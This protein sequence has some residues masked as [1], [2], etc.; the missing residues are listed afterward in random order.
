MKIGI[1]YDVHRLKEGRDLILGGVKIPYPLGLDG[2]SDAD[3]LV[4]AIMDAILGALAMGDIG[5][6]FPD[7]DP[8]Y[9]GASSMGLLKEVAG[10]MDQKGYRIGNVD[11]LLIAQKPKISPYTEEMRKNIAEALGTDTACINVKATTE[12]KLGFTGREEG[13]AAQAVCLLEEKL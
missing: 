9:L 4:H 6:L 8:A 11:A 12:E 7:T 2:H 10:L 1:G 5:R 3:V 13:M